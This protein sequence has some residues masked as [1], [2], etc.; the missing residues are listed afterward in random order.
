L[1]SSN[2]DKTT[3]RIDKFAAP[4][5]MSGGRFNVVNEKEPSERDLAGLTLRA[6][7][8]APGVDVCAPMVPKSSPIAELGW[9]LL[10]RRHLLAVLYQGQR[11]RFE[12]CKVVHGCTT[13]YLS[14]L[15]KSGTKDSAS[16]FVT[17]AQFMKW[18]PAYGS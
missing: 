5:M 10:L 16:Y 15:L 9:Y 17:D 12:N 8:K 13:S 1:V 18:W 14:T 4:H 6:M 7:L 11:L 3:R 2:A